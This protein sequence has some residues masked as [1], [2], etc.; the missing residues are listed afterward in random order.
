MEAEG[1]VGLALRI[2]RIIMRLIE[3]LR[4]IPRPSAILRPNS[5]QY[6][7]LIQG[8]SSTVLQPKTY[9]SLL[10]QVKNTCF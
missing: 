1:F 8:S 10:Q 4:R 9:T 3:I 5:I 6:K 7:P 2:P